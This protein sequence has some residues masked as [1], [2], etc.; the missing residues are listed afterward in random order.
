MNNQLVVGIIV[1]L[2]A[3]YVLLALT[4]TVPKLGGGVR[5]LIADRIRQL[6]QKVKAV[7][8]KS[9][10]TVTSTTRFVIVIDRTDDIDIKSPLTVHN[11]VIKTLDGQKLVMP[12]VYLKS[13]ETTSITEVPYQDTAQLGISQIQY[14]TTG[15]I[16]ILLKTNPDTSKFKPAHAMLRKNQTVLLG[17]NIIND[18]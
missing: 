11:I 17:S 14:S 3:M 6:Q 8:V 10:H 7:I 16:S 2:A 1:G 9:P 15:D 13:Q 5:M 4:H 12:K 18:N